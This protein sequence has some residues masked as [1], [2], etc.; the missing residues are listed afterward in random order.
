MTTNEKLFEYIKASPTPYHAVSHTAELLRKA[1]YTELCEGDK[2]E[3]TE[4]GSYYVTR[5]SSSL[6]SF[7]ISTKSPAGFMIS[8]AHSDSPTFRIK[9][10]SLLDGEYVRLSTEGY[11]GMIC[12]TWLDRPL[13]I[14]GRITV[15]TEHGLEVRLIDSEKPCAL[16]PN[17][18]IH[19]NRKANDGVSYNNAVDMIPLYGMKGCSDLRDVVAGLANVTKE[20]VISHDLM[21]YNAEEGIEW[22]DFISAPRLDDLQCA[23]A[24]LE[25]Y[26]SAE[27]GGS[28]PVYCLFDNEEVGSL[29]KQG[30][31]STFFRDSLERICDSLDG[32][33]IKRM[34]A[35]SFLVSCDNAHATHPNHPELSDKNHSVYMNGGIVIKYNANQKY[36]SDAVSTGMFRLICDEAGAKHQI[37]ANRADMAGGSTLGNISNA[38]VSLLSVDVGLPQ[39]AMHS[40]FETAGKTDTDEMISA[41]KVFFSKSVKLLRDG[42]Y[43]IS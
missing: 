41:L 30:A 39:L 8:A 38:H 21:V 9:D 11:G 2:W 43:V 34:C 19:M 4:G 14:A 12:S 22:N 24:S 28:I 10:N 7:R 13:G 29:T 6:I 33:D 27:N 32:C 17:V 25:A 18:A 23:Y 16:I 3:L 40:S 15:R 5:G 20:D 35:N 37:Y 26:M 31:D 1:G 36:T 42:E